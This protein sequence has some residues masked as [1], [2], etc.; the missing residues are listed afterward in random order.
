VKLAVAKSAGDWSALANANCFY[1][2][3]VVDDERV[4]DA[5][6]DLESHVQDCCD[7][8]GD[9]DPRM[10]RESAKELADMVDGLRGLGAAVS[11]GTKTTRIRLA[12]GTPFDLVVLLVVVAP[13][14]AVKEYAAI[15]KQAQVRLA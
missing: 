9:L 1:F 12:N 6:A 4:R 5:A 11:L 15:P 8:S 14:D 3:C 7:V 10:R 13:K 2:D